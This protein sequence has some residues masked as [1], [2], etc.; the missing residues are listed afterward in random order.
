[1]G[2]PD[3]RAYL[4]PLDNRADDRTGGYV[5]EEQGTFTALGCHVNRTP[6]DER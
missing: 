1:M 5:N 2:Q 3:L 6:C 4:H